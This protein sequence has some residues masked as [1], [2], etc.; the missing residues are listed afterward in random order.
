MPREKLNQSLKELQDELD[1]SERVDDQQ[2]ALLRELSGDIERLL[3][4]HE[5]SKDDDSP[6]EE[7]NERITE[8]AASFESDHPRLAATVRRV[9]SSLSAMG[10]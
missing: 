7:L 6:L 3:E 2:A 8:L 9:M 1:R 10:I 4:S 5:E